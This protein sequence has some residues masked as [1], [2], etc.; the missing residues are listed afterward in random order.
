[1]LVYKKL[2]TKGKGDPVS[3]K[4]RAMKVYSVSWMK[5]KGQFDL[6]H[7]IWENN[8]PVFIAHVTRQHHGQSRLCEENVC[9]YILF[10][11]KTNHNS[12]FIWSVI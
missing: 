8:S 6:D 2:Q 10:Y 1:M 9:M 5:L 3:I 11:R 12:S 7:F 4:P